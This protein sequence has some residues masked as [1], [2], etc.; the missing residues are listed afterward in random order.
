MAQIKP[1]EL[2][3]INDLKVKFNQITFRLGQIELEKKDLEAE[4]I[5][6]INEFN[7]TAQTE[8]ELLDNIQKEYGDG[9]LDLNTGEF[10]PNVTE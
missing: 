7:K 2:Q 5:F 6:L 10:T 4:S 9:N 8:K 1:E 3:S